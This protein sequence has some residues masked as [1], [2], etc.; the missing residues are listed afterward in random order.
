MVFGA[1]LDDPET[2]FVLTAAQVRPP[3]ERAPTLHRRRR[4]RPLRGLKRQSG[5][6]LDGG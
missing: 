4:H 1:A 5:R 3:C 6:P 2:G